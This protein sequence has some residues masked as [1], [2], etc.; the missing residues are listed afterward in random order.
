MGTQA[1]CFGEIVKNPDEVLAKLRSGELHLS[2]RD[3][4]LSARDAA[5]VNGPDEDDD[6]D[7]TDDEED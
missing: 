7:D 6:E 5:L 3:F 2:G 1:S 4:A